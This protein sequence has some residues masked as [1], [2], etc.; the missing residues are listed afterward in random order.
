MTCLRSNVIS[1][2]TAVFICVIVLCSFVCTSCRAQQQAIDTNNNDLKLPLDIPDIITIEASTRKASSAADCTGSNYYSPFKSDSADNSAPPYM[3]LPGTPFDY[4]IYSFKLSNASDFPRSCNI[5]LG[6]T[7]NTWIGYSDFSLKHP[8]WVWTEYKNQQQVQIDFK[9]STLTDPSTSI[10]PTQKFYIAIAAWKAPVKIR[11]VSLHTDSE[12]QTGVPISGIEVPELSAF[13]LKVNKF[14]QDWSIPGG[15]IALSKNGKLIYARGFGF[16]DKENLEIT[17]PWHLFRLA[18]VSK[19]ITAVGIMKLVE[20]GKLSLNSKVFGSDGVL[21]DTQYLDIKDSR[22][23]DITIDQLLHHTSGFAGIVTNS[24]SDDDPMFC[25]Q[26]IASEMGLS[27]PVE[28]AT[29]VQYVISGQNLSTDPG[30]TFFYSNFGYCVLGRVIEKLTGQTYEDYITS[31]LMNPVKAISFQIGKS[32]ESMRAIN[33]IKYYGYPDEPT[34][35][36]VFDNTTEVPWQYGGFYLESMDSH[37]AWISKASDL[38]RFL[39]TVDG[40]EDHPDTLTK[41]SMKTMLTPSTA[42]KNYACGWCVNEYNNWWHIGSLPGS[43]SEFIRTP[44]GFVWV[45]LFNTRASDSNG[46][47]TA[48]DQL[49]WNILPDVKTWPSENLFA[50]GM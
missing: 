9:F 16:G 21:N 36:S 12:I 28:A 31:T 24:G 35:Y 39:L 49:F 46:Y 29:I 37:G 3:S 2:R 32:L 48:L 6:S 7:T 26:Y 25:N 18:S 33:E 44:D 8:H 5:Y 30:T 14:M 38:V 50:L 43:V 22:V 20:A 27:M 4:S 10:S 34:A 40:L 45:A 15:S 23:E 1:V 13:D 41:D 17:Q 19:P 47:H 42:N 11:Q